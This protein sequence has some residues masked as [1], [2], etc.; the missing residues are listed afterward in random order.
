MAYYET[1]ISFFCFPSILIRP[2][3][4]RI[5]YPG[6]FAE[7]KR[8][9]GKI[10]LDSLLAK[11]LFPLLISGVRACAQAHMLYVN[12]IPQHIVFDKAKLLETLNQG[13]QTY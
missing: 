9:N 4:S 1:G 3:W 6:E 10:W 13:S 12:K 11:L 7:G 8:Y 5:G 2:K